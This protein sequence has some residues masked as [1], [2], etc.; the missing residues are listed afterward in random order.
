MVLFGDQSQ[1]IYGRKEGRESVIVQGFGEWNKLTQSYRIKD[2]SPLNSLFQK[3]QRKFLL[4]KYSDTELFAISET[5]DLFSP[6]QIEFHS[7]P[8]NNQLS[9]L[10]DL[11]KKTIKQHTLNPNDIVVLSSKINTVRQLNELWLQEERTHTMFETMEELACITCTLI[12]RLT[13]MSA[14]EIDNLISK[15]EKEIESARRRK[16]N[17]FHQNSGLIKLSTVHSFKGLES[18]TVF[19]LLSEDDSP[20]IVYTGITRATNNLFIFGLDPVEKYANF[21]TTGHFFEREC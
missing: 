11:I 18:K 3:F 13:Q 6:D 17:H 7:C 8:T 14:V 15:Y 1:N 9:F 21:L 4:D 10:F 5:Q 2:N 19:Y 12:T 16:K 20:E